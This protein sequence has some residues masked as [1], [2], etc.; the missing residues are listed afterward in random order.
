[1]R[2]KIPH[3][4]VIAPTKTKHI[5]KVIQ[6]LLHRVN[7]TS[8]GSKNLKQHV[9]HMISGTHI[10]TRLMNTPKMPNAILEDV[11]RSKHIS[12]MIT[13]F[14]FLLLYRL[15]CFFDDGAAIFV[16]ASVSCLMGCSAVVHGLAARA[17]PQ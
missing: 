12:W 16:M 6:R 8:R 14:L 2:H 5:K 3:T 4:H 15:A 11:R 13:K 1:M 7:F 10:S 9:D 17:T